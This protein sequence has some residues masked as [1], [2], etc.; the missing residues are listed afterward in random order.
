[1][2]IC[3]AH[4]S[5]DHPRPSPPSSQQRMGQVLVSEAIWQIE[6]ETIEQALS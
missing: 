2:F 4:Y 1:M 6:L 5:G 3:Q